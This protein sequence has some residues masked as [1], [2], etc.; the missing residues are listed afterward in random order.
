[1]EFSLEMMDFTSTNDGFLAEKDNV[2]QQT[3]AGDGLF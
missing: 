3:G 1:M 2:I